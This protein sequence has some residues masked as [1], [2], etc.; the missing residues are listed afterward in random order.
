MRYIVL[1]LQ[2]NRNIKAFEDAEHFCNDCTKGYL[3]PIDEID[4]SYCPFC[5]KKLTFHKD[6]LTIGDYSDE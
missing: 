3:W 4:Y 5:G 1:K 2:F 6:Y